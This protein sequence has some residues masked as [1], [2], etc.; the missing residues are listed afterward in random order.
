MTTIDVGL[1]DVSNVKSRLEDKN[2]NYKPPTSD[3]KIE[4]RKLFWVAETKL[5][6]RNY[7]YLKKSLGDG[8]DKVH[9]VFKVALLINEVIIEK[10]KIKKW[11]ILITEFIA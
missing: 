3:K 9:K 2:P 7:D 10:V 5:N 6:T 8:M 1:P 11:N 4:S